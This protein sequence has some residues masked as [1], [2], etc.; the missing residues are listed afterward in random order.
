MITKD[1]KANKEIIA[2]EIKEKSVSVIGGAGSNGLKFIK[3]V[4]RLEPEKYILL[5]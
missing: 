2:A 5:I 1:I 3:A 4:F